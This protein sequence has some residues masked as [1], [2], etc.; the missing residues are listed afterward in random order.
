MKNPDRSVGFGVKIR[1]G[2]QSPTF[3]RFITTG[4]LNL[5]YFGKTIAES[6]PLIWPRHCRRIGE[7][8]VGP[9]PDVHRP[10]F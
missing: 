6:F 9:L 5:I 2:A 7:M 8:L 4:R 10:L 1:S 3:A